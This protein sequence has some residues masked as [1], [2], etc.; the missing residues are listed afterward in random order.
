MASLATDVSKAHLPPALVTSLDRG[1]ARFQKHVASVNVNADGN[2]WVIHTDTGRLKIR[3]SAA[4]DN[5]VRIFRVSFRLKSKATN[6]SVFM[7][8][9]MDMSHRSSW[10]VSIKSGETR[11]EYDVDAAAVEKDSSKETYAIVAYTTNA[12]AAGIVSS[13]WFLDA[14][15]MIEQLDGSTFCVTVDAG[16]SGLLTCPPSHVQAKNYEGS[17][18]KLQLVGTD[19][20]GYSIWHCENLAHCNIGGYLPT[21][22][23][24]RETGGAMANTYSHLLDQLLKKLE[25]TECLPTDNI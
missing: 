15:K 24:N 22:L 23:V 13:R 1:Y 4:H 14:R 7:S 11:V 3:Y 10:D 6:V 2:P 25:Q 16:A 20:D 12:T 9:L 17:A 8:D 5:S 21:W 18:S 19:E